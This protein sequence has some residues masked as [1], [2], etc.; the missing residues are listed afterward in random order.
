ME[1]VQ[2]VVYDLP[3]ILPTDD[4]LAFMPELDCVLVV[5]ADGVTTKEELEDSREMLKH[6]NVLGY[7]LNQLS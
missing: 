2:I 5:L 6:T 1:D 4:T 3:P 7:V